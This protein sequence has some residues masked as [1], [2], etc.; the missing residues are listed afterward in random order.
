MDHAA[1]SDVS[2]TRE[3][4]G[5]HTRS[6]VLNEIRAAG[7]I[8]RVEL[9]SSVGVTA[10]SISNV[11]RA[12]LDEGM[13]IEVG[14]SAPTGGKPRTLLA[15]NL[16]SRFALG[17]SL[18][19]HHIGIV[20][21]DLGG[22][23]VRSV[24]LAG[25][26]DQAP[27]EVFA[28][29]WDAIRALIESSGVDA[30]TVV[31]IGIAG[32][33][34]LHTLTGT[35]QGL[36]PSPRWTG[37]PVEKHLEA[38]SGLPVLLDNDATCAALGEFW[39]DRTGAARAVSATVFMSDGIGCGILVDGRVFHGMTSNAGELGH[40]SLDPEGPACHCGARGCVEVYASP[41]SVV[42]AA[43]AIPSAASR[44]RISGRDDSVL[45]DF[46]LICA[47]ASAGDEDAVSI[48]ARA[49]RALAR[50]VVILS[51]ILDLDEVR[52]TGPGFAV[53][54]GLYA[55]EMQREL[56][57]GTFMRSVHPVRVNVSGAGSDAAALGAAAL[58]LQHRIT[59][60]AAATAR[61]KTGTS[62]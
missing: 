2:G 35:L 51:N 53:S 21:C 28:I 23:P 42:K 60:H 5:D 3:R 54:R 41:T 9:A 46:G 11:T 6:T 31:G 40:I 45:E 62:S 12:L 27:Q 29:V 38:L 30:A 17:V 26:G 55:P 13:V 57:A 61:R 48:V 15:L 59:P 34:P 39:T 24:D 49:A 50:A 25:A 56:D 22:Q 18:G 20:L 10:A 33:G 58:I 4:A 52:L 7:S 19:R 47:A 32:P 37:F 8:S 44:W 1:A 16:R 43:L 14:F 36:R